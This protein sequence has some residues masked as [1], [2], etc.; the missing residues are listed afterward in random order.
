MGARVSIAVVALLALAIAVIHPPA[1]SAKWNGSRVRGVSS[2][3]EGVGSKAANYDVSC[4]RGLKA[5]GG[6]FSTFGISVAGDLVPGG[7]AIAVVPVVFESRLLNARTWRVTER[8]AVNPAAG[9]AAP[10][11]TSVIASVYCR[12][13][14]G[15]LTTVEDIGAPS[16]TPSSPSSADPRC[17][18]GR[19]AVGGGWSV[20]LSE[21]SGFVYPSIYESFRD[22]SRAWKTSAIPGSG[23]S[24]DTFGLVYC[25][26]ERKPPRTSRRT[27]TSGLATVGCAKGLAAAAGG[28][29]ATRGAV[30]QT[31]TGSS[32]GK[33]RSYPPGKAYPAGPSWG[34]G[35]GTFG[36]A[37][38]SAATVFAYCT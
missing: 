29:Q 9:P 12:K 31:S 36:L 8:A 22:G 18:R 28:F 10:Q 15:R 4:P 7:S 24:L 38:T 3:S 17:P 27:V 37:P 32:G 30:I 1:A 16:S 34:V 2:P 35:A 21:E 33:K 6:G 11:G 20:Q 25:A 5:V 23:E 19:V 14:K 13:V 26:R